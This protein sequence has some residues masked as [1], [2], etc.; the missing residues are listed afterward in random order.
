MDDN[1]FPSKDMKKLIEVWQQE[2]C[3]WNISLDGTT[4]SSSSV[5]TIFTKALCIYA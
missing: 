1:D 4:I 5:S 2:E 3:L